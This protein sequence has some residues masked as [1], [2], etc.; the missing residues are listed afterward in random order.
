M[1]HRGFS[2]LGL[3]TLDLDRTRAFYEGVLG[4]KP[5]VAYG[6]IVLLTL[7]GIPLSVG[8]EPAQAGRQAS[9]VA[10]VDAIRA[11]WRNLSHSSSL[12]PSQR[13]ATGDG[14]WLAGSQINYAYILIG[15]ADDACGAGKVEQAHSYVDEANN[16]LNPASSGKMHA[17]RPGN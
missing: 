14:H 16:L 6:L 11:E 3:S 1:T 17:A 9:C 5:V 15:R 7:T 2:H 10:S 13:V 4:F 12:K 8:A